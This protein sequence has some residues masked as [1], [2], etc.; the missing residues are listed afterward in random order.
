[1][2]LASE[3]RLQTRIVYLLYAHLSW[4]L[5]WA[6]SFYNYHWYLLCYM[7]SFLCAH[8]ITCFACGVN[9]YFFYSLFF[10]YRHTYYSTMCGYVQT[11]PWRFN[12]GLLT[13]SLKYGICHNTLSSYMNKASVIR[14]MCLFCW[15]KPDLL[16]KVIYSR[17]VED[18]HAS[19]SN[20]TIAF[21][22]YWWSNLLLP[23]DLL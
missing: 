17:P 14:V 5:L 2:F 1:M 20:S 12:S 15:R 11:I 8:N 10:I 4:S 22:N 16:F 19:L 3:T 18:W 7:L 13:A 21:S 9:S 23:R 6:F